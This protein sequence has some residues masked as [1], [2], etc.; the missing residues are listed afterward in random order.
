MPTACALLERPSLSFSIYVLRR[1]APARYSILPRAAGARA[2]QDSGCGSSRHQRGTIGIGAFLCPASLAAP[3]WLAGRVALAS[4]NCAIIRAPLGRL[5]QESPLLFKAEITVAQSDFKMTFLSW[6]QSPAR[7]IPSRQAKAKASPPPQLIA[8]QKPFAR[9]IDVLLYKPKHLRR[10]DGSVVFTEGQEESKITRSPP[11]FARVYGK[12]AFALRFER[13]VIQLMAGVLQLYN[14]WEVQILVL[15]SLALQVFLLSFAGL[16]RRNIPTVLRIILWLMYLLADSIA[17]Y[18]L[19]HMSIGYKLGEHQQLMA[20]WA[21]FLLVHLGG[22]DTITAYAME[23]N[24]L[25]LRHLLTLVMQAVGV[26]YVL[27]KYVAGSGTAFMSAAILMFSI[28]VI[29]YGERV[30]SLKVANLDSVSKFM[31]TVKLENN[32]GTYPAGIQVM[33]A[34]VILQGAHDMLYICMGQFVDD[35]IWPSE[36][37]FEAIKLFY[38]KKKMYELIEMQLSLMYDIFYT[39]A[40]VVYTWHGFCIRAF[41]VVGTV[42]ACLLFQ[43]SVSKNGYNRIDVTTTYVLLIGALVLEV[44][45]VLW[46]LMSTWTCAA[47]KARRWDRLHWLLVSLRRHVKAAQIKRT[48]SASIGRHNLLEDSSGKASLSGI[49]SSFFKNSA[50]SI[51][52][53]TK[54]LVLTEMLRLVEACNGDENIMKSYRGNQFELKRQSD[55]GLEKITWTSG[56]EFDESILLWHFATDIFLFFYERERGKNELV[57]ATKAVSNYM[58]FLLVE[59]PYMLPSPVRSRLY[60]SARRKLGPM[61][62]LGKRRMFEHIRYKVI[63]DYGDFPHILDPGAKLAN[64]LLSTNWSDMMDVLNVIFGVWVQKLSYAAHHCSRDSHAKQLNNGGGEFI[65]VIW[66]LTTALF[67][68]YNSGQVSYRQRAADFFDAR[69]STQSKDEDPTKNDKPWIGA[70]GP[71]LQRPMVDVRTQFHLE[72][73][74][75]SGRL[76]TTYLC[77]ERATGLR[78]ACKSVSKRNLVRHADVEDMRREIT[79]LQHLSGQP[80][81]VEFK[82]AFEDPEYVH[83]VMEFCSG[84][85]LERHIMVEGPFS[86]HKAATMFRDIVTIVHVCHFMGVMHLDLRAENLLLASLAKDAP[87]KVIDFGQSV[88]IEEGKVYKDTVGDPLYVAPEAIRGNY[89]KEVDVWSAGVIL[90]LILYGSLP[91]QGDTKEHIFHDILDQPFELTLSWGSSVSERAKDLLLRML[92]R[93]PQMRITAAQALEHPW[94]KGRG[95]PNRPIDSALLPRMKQFKAMNKL[96]QLALKVIAENLSPEELKG[97]KQM[98]NNMDTDKSGTITVEELKEG[99]RKL[100]SEISEA[101]VEKLVEAVDLNKSGSIDYTEF[102]TAMMNKHKVENEADLLRAFQHFD[103]YSSGYIT[104]DELEQAMA[105]Y[106]MGDEAS[107][108][109]VLDEVD[110]DKDGRIDYEEFAEMMRK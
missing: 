36:F 106:G 77:T 85:N 26:A 92:N 5:E 28:G 32:K 22:Q 20:F 25:W 87:L 53:I 96:K 33:D 34:E 7:P 19:G 94:L 14:E 68:E 90:Y 78:Y 46:I 97:L 49:M 1:P 27:Y 63:P 102:L 15:F 69:H 37:Q 50:N 45:S 107:I 4:M 43:F 18:I 83:L 89:G 47:L 61:L 80:N 105:E 79:I 16:R 71:A 66:L 55:G 11:A 10:L 99:L 13:L 110:R 52:P 42:T 108:K 8:R 31:D 67:H 76:G 40:T 104:R 101:E 9:K 72:R 58:M 100:G 35:N 103:K 88:F 93:D 30:Q 41:S 62:L 24:N 54:E 70:F 51:S 84:G 74:L 6:Y 82:G 12:I 21:S 75:G 57:E 38:D 65:T 3:L 39:K 17:V 48:W 81:I 64:Q 2:E 95:A 98:F 73:K 86:E 59:H 29:K 56:I 109:Q 91:F 60:L 44:A 23:D